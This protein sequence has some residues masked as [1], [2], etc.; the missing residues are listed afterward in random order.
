LGAKA[1]IKGNQMRGDG[2]RGFWGQNQSNGGKK[3]EETE[4]AGPCPRK[5]RQPENDPTAETEREGRDARKTGKKRLKGGQDPFCGGRDTLV[6][7][8]GKKRGNIRAT[9]GKR[10]SSCG[11]H[12]GKRP[13]TPVGT[14]QSQDEKKKKKKK[15]KKKRKKKKKK[16]KKVFERM[17]G[18]TKMKILLRLVK[19]NNWGQ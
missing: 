16:K 6:T 17:V 4:G 7:R 9:R 12:C 10:K 15:K 2:Q 3:A 11:S 1:N 19:T 18:G 13:K 8:G 5:K 14:P